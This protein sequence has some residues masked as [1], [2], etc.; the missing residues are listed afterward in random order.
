ML[1]NKHLFRNKVVLDVGC[2]TGVL[3]MFAAKAGAKKV[4]GIECSS[5]VEHARKI[6]KANNLDHVV[7]P[8]QVCTNTTLIKEVDLYTVKV[9]DMDFQTPFELTC[10]RDDFV[11]GLV[12][13]FSVD[14]SKCHKRV[15][16]C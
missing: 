6:V 2:G 14:F 12:S 15:S 5:I 9:E 13:F 11:H 4:I 16:F 3:S 8:K 7:E 10:K 1:H